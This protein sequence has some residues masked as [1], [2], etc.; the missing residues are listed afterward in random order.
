MATTQNL[1][2]KILD[3]NVLK[4]EAKDMGIPMSSYNEALLCIALN[5]LNKLTSEQRTQ[6]LA[7]ALLQPNVPKKYLQNKTK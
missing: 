4:A 1:S 3:L 6:E 7:Q 5:K 2:F